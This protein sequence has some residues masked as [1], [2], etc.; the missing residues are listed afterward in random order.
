MNFLYYLKH[1]SVLLT[2]LWSIVSSANFINYSEN[3]NFNWAESYLV[4]NEES[5]EKALP[6]F[7]QTKEGVYIGVGTERSFVGAAV[8]NATHLLL[9]DFDQDILIYNRMMI[10]LFKFAKNKDEFYQ[11]RTNFTQLADLFS[12]FHDSPLSNESIYNF[13]KRYR[14][15]KLFSKRNWFYVEDSLKRPETSFWQ[16][17]DLYQKLHKM[18][19]ENKI[20]V[21]DLDFSKENQRLKLVNAIKEKNLTISMLDLSNAWQLGYIGRKTYSALVDFLPISTDHSLYMATWLESG[22]FNPY[23]A[24]YLKRLIQESPF[25]EGQILGETAI[26]FNRCAYVLKGHD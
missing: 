12:H 25:G 15:T 21:V 10:E 4:P 2:L 23:H 22:I 6:I 17:E 26:N 5:I 8:S 13:L 20:Q 16:N 3:N 19:L 11:I 1:L 9:A 7:S 14:G 24:F 18:A